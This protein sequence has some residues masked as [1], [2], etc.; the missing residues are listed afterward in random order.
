M[1]VGALLKFEMLVW[2]IV[3]CLGTD[4]VQAIA[5]SFYTSQMLCFLASIKAKCYWFHYQMVK[6]FGSLTNFVDLNTSKIPVSR[7]PI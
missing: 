7:S 5:F 1:C 3:T 4:L 6:I 2:R